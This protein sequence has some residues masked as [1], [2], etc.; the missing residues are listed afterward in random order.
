[1]SKCCCDCLACMVWVSNCNFV[2]FQE[3][4][5]LAEMFGINLSKESLKHHNK[6][7]MHNINKVS[8]L[9]GMLS[10]V[11]WLIYCVLLASTVQC[12]VP[13]ITKMPVIYRNAPRNDW[14]SLYK[15]Q[16]SPLNNFFKVM[17]WKRDWLCKNSLYGKKKIT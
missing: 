15:Y 17:Y 2:S 8:I 16:N 6:E 9:F 14:N 7:V 4:V 13:E 1:M 5:A 10:Y 3:L 12:P 11:C